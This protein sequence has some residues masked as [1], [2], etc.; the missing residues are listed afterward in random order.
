M[1]KNLLDT[2]AHIK[3]L[4]VIIGLLLVILSFIAQFLPVLDFLTPGQW[5]LH[6]GIIIGLGGML[7]SDTL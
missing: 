3:G 7:F 4:P 5:V 1:I 2:L 6:L